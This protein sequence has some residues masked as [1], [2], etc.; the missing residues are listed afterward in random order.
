MRKIIA[1]ATLALSALG[2]ASS[3]AAPGPNGRNDYGLCTA[4][5]AGSSTG[6]AAK[7]KAPPFQALEEAAGVDDD[8]SADEV[9]QKVRDFCSSTTPGGNGG[10]PGNPG[11]DQPK[12]KSGR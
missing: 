11:F 3:T 5:F 12:G 8:D 6:Q 7:H 9:E 10:T 2:L 1:V 4:Y